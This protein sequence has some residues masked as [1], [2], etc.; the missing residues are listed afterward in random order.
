M[1]GTYQELGDEVL[2]FRCHVGREAE[3]HPADAA[4]GGLVAFCLERGVA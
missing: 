4:I 3:V 1:G 2:G